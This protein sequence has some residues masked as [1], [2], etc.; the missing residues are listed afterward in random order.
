MR[1]H[2]IIG[3]LDLTASE[4][5]MTDILNFY[6]TPNAAVKGIAW[7]YKLLTTLSKDHTSSSITFWSTFTSSPPRP[8]LWHK[9]L[10]IP[11]KASKC[12]SHWESMQKLFHKWYYTPARL[13]NIYPA[14][15]SQCWRNCSGKG[16][17]RHIWWDCPNIHQYWKEVSDLISQLCKIPLPLSPLDLLLGLNIPNWPKNIRVLVTHILIAARLALTK[18]WKASQ[19]PSG[20]E[21]I[22]LLNN[23][24]LMEFSFAKANMYTATFRLNWKPWI[25]DSRSTTLP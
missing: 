20:S 16:T 1:L 17:L 18:K 7:I 9:A 6:N 8:P 15:S 4:S 24:F 2:S 12:I 21:L 23:H 25:T 13:A 10:T 5:Q 19:A 11:L 14:T 3:K 22:A